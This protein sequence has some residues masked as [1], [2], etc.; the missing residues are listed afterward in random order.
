LISREGYGRC[1]DERS[2]ASVEHAASLAGASLATG[3]AC[4]AIRNAAD[5]TRIVIAA[6][7]PR[8][9]GAVAANTTIA[10]EAADGPVVRKR[11]GF[12]RHRGSSQVE[13]ST[14]LADAR[15]SACTARPSGSGTPTPDE[16][17]VIIAAGTADGVASVPTIAS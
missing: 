6:V 14:A 7:S 17:Y 2:A 3:A 13:Q 15:G 4:S 12:V 9:A 11:A 16:A 1:T 10:A 5:T 8:A